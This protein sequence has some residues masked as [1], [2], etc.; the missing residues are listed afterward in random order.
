MAVAWSFP[1]VRWEALK[2]S[3][4]LIP[5]KSENDLRPLPHRKL[6][7]S[8]FE[9]RLLIARECRWQADLL[10]GLTEPNHDPSLRAN[11]SRERAPDDRLR[12]MP[13][14]R[15]GVAAQKHQTHLA[16]ALSDSEIS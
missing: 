12:D 13:G 6:K 2:G 16:G 4:S 11:G 9:E 7:L 3:N 15:P 14:S 5:P 1:G 10:V 8:W